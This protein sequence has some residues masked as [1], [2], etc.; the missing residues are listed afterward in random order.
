MPEIKEVNYFFNDAL[1][2]EGPARY[3]EFFKAAPKE[4]VC[5]EAS[6]GYICHPR[7][8]LRIHRQLPDVKLI[9]TVR[10][11]VERAYSQYWDNRRQLQEPRSFDAL[12]EE[13][14][15]QTFTPER[16]NYFSRG[17][18]SVYLERYLA[19]FPRSQILVVQFDELKS[20]P[21]AVY[22]KCFEFIGVDPSFSSDEQRQIANFRSVFS[23]PLYRFFF[24][25]PALAT[26][27]PSVLRWLLRW[28][29]LIPY[30]PDPIS[31]TTES[32]LREF[33][34]PYDRAL[35]QLLGE[36]LYWCEPQHML[37]DTAS[38]AMDGPAPTGEATEPSPG[39]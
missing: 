9:L 3:A 15:H 16:R 1:F 6:P 4:A 33:F 11:P 8:P 39:P 22:R 27:L 20:D 30:T 36:S 2:S 25:R 35:A 14:L 37:E 29:K 34:A 21:N 32:R 26:R 7:A 23:N 28:G 5:G 19:L 10:D 13:P 31:E 24:N 12:L 38:A 17:L 18:Y